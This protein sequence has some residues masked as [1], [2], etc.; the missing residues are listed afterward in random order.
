MDYVNELLRDVIRRG[1]RPSLLV[2]TQRRQPEN[3]TADDYKTRFIG[4]TTGVAA[5][6]YRPSPAFAAAAATR[7]ANWVDFIQNASAWKYVPQNFAIPGNLR[8]VELCR[9]SGGVAT[10]E[11]K[12]EGT[13]YQAQLPEMM[14]PHRYCPN[15]LGA[16][17]GLPT[18]DLHSLNLILPSRRLLKRPLRPPSQ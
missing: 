16:L 7:A 1:P 12:A 2:R 15:H 9:A 10:P 6:V 5:W 14:I 4:Y 18:E 8:P 11:C 3:R 13:M 17:A